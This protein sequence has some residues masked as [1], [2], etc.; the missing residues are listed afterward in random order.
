MHL[1]IHNLYDDIDEPIEIK[2]LVKDLIPYQL[3]TILY[4]NHGAY[5]SVLA[6]HIAL[7]VADGMEICGIEPKQSNVLL[8]A[9][10]GIN[11]VRPRAKAHQIHYGRNNVS[12]FYYAASFPF[13]FGDKDA[14]NALKVEIEKLDIEVLIFDTLSLARPSGTLNDD[15]AASIVTR[16]LKKYSEDWGVTTITIG[17]TGKDS[18]RGLANS[19]VLQNDVPCILKVQ[20]K[21]LKVEKQRSGISG[22]TYP[23]AIHQVQ[24]NDK[25]DTAICLEW[26]DEE[27]E[28]G[29]IKVLNAIKQL[30]PDYPAGIPRKEI[31][32]YLWELD[33]RQNEGKSYAKTFQSTVNRDLRVL[34]KKGYINKVKTDLETL[35][36]LADSKGKQGGNNVS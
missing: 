36:S 29:Q 20:S 33:P 34:V 16:S 18:R 6:L 1:D 13:Q 30:Q 24:I 17:H 26:V 4:G 11:D 7:C 32:E 31:A 12:G 3:P 25:G 28:P 2:W 9:L 23:F 22:A 5:K 27:K 35:F 15:G 14:E 19:Q 21:K 8:L 10:E